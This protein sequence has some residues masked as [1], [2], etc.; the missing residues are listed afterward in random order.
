MELAAVIYAIMIWRHY[1]YGEKCHM[2]TDHKS[3]KY[4]STRKEFNLRQYRWVELLKDYDFIVDYHPG[5]ANVVAHELIRKVTFEL[6]A[7]F[8][9]L[10]IGNDDNL[11]VELKVKTMLFNQIRGAQ[12]VNAKLMR[13]REM[14]QSGSIENFSINDCDGPFAMHY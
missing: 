10:S 12:L 5:K 1:L 8:A 6:R 9:R 4:L 2:F 7:M 3:L 11:M 14:V 13:I